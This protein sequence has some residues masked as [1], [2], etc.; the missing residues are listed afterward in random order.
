M[1]IEI[2][3]AFFSVYVFTMLLE[4]PRCYKI[5]SAVAGA[6]C[7]YVYLLMRDRG[8]SPMAATFYSMLVVALISHILARYLKASMTVFLVSGFLPVVPGTAI[9]RCVYYLLLNDTELSTHYLI[10]TVQIAGA[11]AMAVFIMDSV[12]RLVQVYHEN[13]KAIS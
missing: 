1:I 11:I 10:E 4:V 5:H 6:V 9:Y 2:L 7:W 12:F 8:S 13:R 3:S